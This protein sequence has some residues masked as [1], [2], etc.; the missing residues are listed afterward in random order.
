M[1]KRLLFILCF[2]CSAA[3]GSG[4]DQ[5]LLVHKKSGELLSIAVDQIDSI[6]FV[7]TGN[8]QRNKWYFMLENPGIADYLRD[9][10][11]D[12]NDYTYHRIFDY[13]GEPYLDARQDWP[14]GVD[15]GDTVIY[16]LVPNRQYEVNGIRFNTLGQLRMLRLEGVNNVRDL[17]GWPLSNGGRMRYGCIVRG[18]ELNTSLPASDASYRLHQATD[19]DIETL[20]DVVGIRAELDLRGVTELSRDEAYDL[21]HSALGANVAYANVQN[22]ST[23]PI[24][25]P[26]PAW[27]E[28]LTFIVTSLQK[29]QPMYVHCRWGADRTGLLCMLLEGVLG[30]SESDLAKDFELT[31]F[32]GNTRYRTDSRF[33]ESIAYIK[34]LPGNTLQ[35]KFRHYWLAC[36]ATAEQLDTLASLMTTN[37]SNPEP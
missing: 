4:Q 28:A 5:S 33:R 19:A 16:N 1:I 11:Y 34:S 22:C 2:T 24:N 23:A 18:P 32:C 30:M 25:G 9:F 3:L 29:H 37:P 36:G 7:E 31:S 35:E 26:A 13:R 15:L 27:V 10:E 14:Y 20:R 21:Q 17:G 6:R 8:V 12:G